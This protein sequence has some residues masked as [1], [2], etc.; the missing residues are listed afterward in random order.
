M[1]PEA[2]PSIFEIGVVSDRFHSR[3]V[4]GLATRNRAAAEPATRPTLQLHLPLLVLLF[5]GSGCAA[6][7][8]EVVWFQFLQIVIG[9]SAVS[10]GVLLG[11][12]MGGMC[13]GSA[14]APHCA[15][16][17]RH[18]LRVYALL[19][20]TI[21]AYG[22]LLLVA[23]PLVNDIYVKFGS[24]H[25]A[26]RMAIACL[27]LLPPSIAMGATLPIIARWIGDSRAT[28]SWLGVFYAGNLIGAVAGAL[29]AGFYLLRVFDL[30]V[31]TWTAAAINLVLAMAAS[32]IAGRTNALASE[33]EIE[34]PILTSGGASLIYVAIALSGATALSAQVLW[35]RL[36]SLAFG[37]TVYAFS[38]ILAAFLIGLGVGSSL[39][40]ILVGQTDLRPRVLLGWC[41][42]LLCVAIVW[43]AHLL[44]EAM[45]YWPIDA[46]VRNSAWATFRQDLFRSLLV[47]LP[48][49]ALWGASFP[50][51]LASLAVPFKDTSRVVGRVYAA[52]TAGAIAG[53]LGTSLLLA[54]SLG[55]QHTEQLMIAIA[56]ISGAIALV[57][58]R[59]ALD[60]R[61]ST[62]RFLQ[63]EGGAIA[64]SAALLIMDVSP[65]P[66]VLIAYGRQ[67]AEWV[68]TAR[69][70]DPGT[71]IYTGEGLNDFVAVSRAGNG[72]LYFHASGKVQ[73]STATQDLRLQLLLAHLS[74]LVP[75]HPANVLV[76]GCGAGITAG[77]LSI[78]PGVER[79]TI[80]EIEPLVPQAAS[81]Y[82]GDYNYH[83]I[84]NPRVSIQLDDGRH[85]LATTSESFDVITTDLID[86]WAKGVA[87]LFTRE[88][89]ELERRHLRPG[90]VVTQFV[91]LYQS[92][93]EAVKSE[94]GTF[95]EVF[96]NAA[97]WGNPREG[98]GYDLVL[99]G[100]AEP[101]RID[102]DELQ[103]R[104]ETPPYGRVI[105]SLHKIGINS[106]VELMSTYVGSGPDLKPWVR[107]AAI[108]RD[109][110]L[111]LQYLAGLGLNLEENGPIYRE[112]LQYERFP[113]DMFMGSRATIQTLQEALEAAS[114][115][116]T[117]SK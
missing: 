82:F 48:G 94:I 116:S 9:S 28:V 4:R 97:V 41:Q 100:Q 110:N 69:V 61:G 20:L 84:Q 102:V 56:A 25:I 64:I 92:S 111:R 91:Q 45:P 47:V 101:V 112:M 55:T 57:S 18:P 38:L 78:A 65:V 108:N 34:S 16:P 75:K 113:S 17:R 105:E 90:G 107:D 59:W 72:D 109:D 3:V 15:S 68:A 14:L 21:G 73:A 96:P 49:A 67:A 5:F 36:L 12:F 46:A 52:N 50:L 77:A 54:R 31:A 11:T 42:V 1:V 30:R 80:A 95:L 24:G 23:M 88:F 2:L 85:F 63:I 43:A 114:R 6:L 81:I 79:M 98:Q 106:A 13:L 40:S 117:N 51:A 76:I 99:L 70:A 115:G 74:H 66:G 26:V 104:L 7:I 35:T 8:Y 60:P 19:E 87:A 86:P 71:I 89:F 29:L 10:L 37:A 32:I 22:V 39:G 27:C 58:A 93:P 44:T 83:V 53:S 103:A 33:S 62:N